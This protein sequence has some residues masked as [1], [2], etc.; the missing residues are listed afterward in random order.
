MHDPLHAFIKV[1]D[2]IDYNYTNDDDNDNNDDDNDNYDDKDNDD[3]SSLL[4]RCGV[5]R[6]DCGARAHLLLQRERVEGF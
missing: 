1:V 5:V 3:G 2:N 4:S 6:L